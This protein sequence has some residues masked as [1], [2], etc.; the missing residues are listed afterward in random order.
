M[1][2]KL[3]P[4]IRKESGFTL[5]EVMFALAI[6]MVS[7]SAIILTQ[8]GSR[9]ALE[10]TR[11]MT[12]V[13]MLAKNSMVDAETYFQ[14]K[15]F[16]EVEEEKTGT[17]DSPYEQYSWKRV[18]KEVE[19]PDLNSLL[20]SEDE[21]SGVTRTQEMMLKLITQY[22]SDSLR[23]VTVTITWP[24]G[25]GTKSYSLTTYWVDLSREFSIT[26]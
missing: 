24:K 5:V 3:L 8:S 12:T 9:D 19:F 15:T 25:K 1:I 21:E 6:M 2:N 10:R 14:D 22:I 20:S 4:E 18:I 7:F 26:Q 16:N 13:S 23:E 17:F 11:R